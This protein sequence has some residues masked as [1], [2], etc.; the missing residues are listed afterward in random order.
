MLTVG[1]M[2]HGD[3]LA[4][5]QILSEALAHLTGDW[6]LNIAGDGP[7]RRQVEALMAPFGQRVRFLG[8]L[9]RKELQRVYQQSSLLAWP[10]VNEAYGMIYLEA[11]AAADRWAYTGE[12]VD[13]ESLDGGGTRQLRARGDR[14][15]ELRWLAVD[16]HAGVGERV[17]LE[18]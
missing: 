2:R 14:E 9:D 13:E 1:M 18:R 4:S 16:V 17:N 7:A 3:K 10:G 8:L 11:Q 6:H 5:Y 12:L 15:A